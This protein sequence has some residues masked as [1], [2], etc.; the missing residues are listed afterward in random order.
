[1]PIDARLIEAER[2][3]LWQ[4]IARNTAGGLVRASSQ[5]L[6]VIQANQSLASQVHE[7][8]QSVAAEH[9][10]RVILV[11]VS[12]AEPTAQVAVHSPGSASPTATWEQITLTGGP[13]DLNRIMSAVELLVLPNLPVKAW[14]P[15]DPRNEEL[16][17]GRVIEI[18][19][20]VIVDSCSFSDAVASMTWYARQSAEEH[21]VVGFVDLGWRRLEPWRVL[22]AQFFDSSFDRPFLND[23]QSVVIE[24]RTV[25]DGAAG[26]F[27]EALLLL[28]WLAS[29][30]GWSPVGNSS[31]QEPGT[32]RLT[33]QTGGSEL[34]ASLRP[35]PRAG[36][37][38]GGLIKV[39]LRA[40]YTGR[41]ALYRIG[42]SGENVAAVARVDGA[43][44]KAQ[45]SLPV[46]SEA[47]LLGRELA[48]FGRD[49]IYEEALQVVRLLA[50]LPG[51]V[52]ARP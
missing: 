12:N 32:Q 43:R 36:P 42:C 40:A 45:L 20:R 2:E 21:G 13:E 50:E 38:V 51:L 16:L 10:C 52:S 34:M 48:D 47:D 18:A 30:L 3:R 24:Y 8:L 35:R 14:W 25:Q 39:E 44:R 33:F 41:S 17:F 1:M 29:R 9:R 28:G 7:V 11:A 27:S 5:S 31:E 22:L 19:E 26:G 46:Q 15:G 4:R 37:P 6:L 23:I 49:R